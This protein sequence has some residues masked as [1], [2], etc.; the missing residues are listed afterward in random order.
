MLSKGMTATFT[1]TNSVYTD[2]YAFIGGAVYCS[3][4]QT[5]TFTSVTF[6]NNIAQKGGAIAYVISSN[7][8]TS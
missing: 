2:G 7:S 1:D 8:P 3:Y 6:T 5:M 4:C